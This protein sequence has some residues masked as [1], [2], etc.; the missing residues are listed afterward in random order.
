MLQHGGLSVDF[1]SVYSTEATDF[2]TQTPKKCSVN[3]GF[4]V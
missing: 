1:I 3:S 2:E 4:S